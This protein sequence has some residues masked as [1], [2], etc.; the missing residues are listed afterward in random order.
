MRKLWALIIVLLGVLTLAAC[1]PTDEPDPDPDPDPDPTVNNGE[2]IDFSQTYTQKESITV[3]MDDEAGDYMDALIAEFNDVY[4]NIVVNFEHKGSVDSRE[5][6]KTFGPSGNGADVFQFPHDH[7]AQA[8]LED[9]VYPLPQSTSDLLDGRAAQI[10]LDIATL[11]YDESA[12]SFDPNSPNAVEQ[13]YAV[14]ISLESIGLFYNTDLID[15]PATTFEALLAAADTWNAADAPGGSGLTNAESGNYYLATSSH[16]ADSYFMQPIYSAFGF[17][18]FGANL[19][20]PEEV[21][22]ESTEAIAALNWINTEL[23]P[24]V[25]GNG[26][27]D[28]VTGGANFESGLAPYIIG[29]PWNIEAYNNATGLNY[30]IAPFPTINGNETQT[31][32][33]AQMAAVYKYSENKEAAIKWVEFLNTDVAMELLYEYKGKL[34]ALETSLLDDIE[35]VSSDT[36]L[37]AI[38]AQLASSVPMPT[39]PQVTYYW[40]PGETMIQQIWNNAVAVATAA[41]EA[42]TSYQTSVNLAG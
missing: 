40:G 19:D 8:V 21:G 11:S 13:L 26:N 35:G 30:A 1:T 2:L 10:G 16:W 25:T 29:G 31:F 23:R 41:E 5:L 24:R 32:A 4:P 6:L 39:I 37:L 17:Y 34:P 12:Q 7:L 22:F 18:P 42:E 20:D 28:S 27:H 33:G 3:W 15:T 9:L 38:S 36:L 14:P